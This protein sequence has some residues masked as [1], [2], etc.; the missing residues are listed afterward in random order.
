MT[1]YFSEVQNSGSHRKAI[2]LKADTLTSAKREATKKSYFYDT[3]LK[4]GT[5][6][7]ND[8]LDDDSVVCLKNINGK[9]I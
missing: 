5:E 9:W 1:Y 3:V 6:L 8:F 4:I 2:E 7:D